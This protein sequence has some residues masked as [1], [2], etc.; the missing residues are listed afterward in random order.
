MKLVITSPSFCKHPVLVQEIKNLKN[1]ESI[2]FN[3]ESLRLTGEDLISFLEDADAW[4]VGTELVDEKVLK[5]CPN[6][7]LISKY[8]VGLDNIDFEACEKYGVKINYA[9]GVNAQS[10]A[11]LALGNI[12]ALTH[13]SYITANLLKRGI[14]E[15]SGGIQLFNK[16]MGI[17]GV[18]YVG[19]KLIN[20]LQNFN[21][22]ILVNDLLDETQ[23]QQDF[24]KAVGAQPCELNYLLAQSDVVSIHTP[25]TYLTK[26]L[27]A[28]AELKIMKRTSFLIN[29]ARG[30]IINQQD[31][32]LALKN[33]LIAGAAVDVYET[34]PCEDLEFLSLPNLIATPH[35]GGNA[36]EAVEAM[37]RAAIEGIL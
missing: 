29:T 28:E 9:Q 21:C 32:K 19:K 6:I 3:L 2:K 35:I 26:N 36:L 25:L 13:N 11:E 33:N 12:L 31:L 14:W 34:E 24:Y 30:P 16:T 18:G 23:S 4:L 15:K 7:K 10:V 17:I 8:G 5:A 1:I 22:K 37:G 20:L 27:I